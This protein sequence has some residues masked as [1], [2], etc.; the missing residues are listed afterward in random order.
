M[1]YIDIQPFLVKLQI[2]GT[3]DLKMIDTEYNPAKISAWKKSGRIR[4][5]IRGF[6]L[7]G[8]TEVNLALLCKMSNKIYAPSYVSLESAFSYYGLIPEQSFRITAVSMDKTIG[9][10]TD[11]ANFSYRKMKSSLFW[12]YRTVTVNQTKFQMAEIE[13]AIVDYLYLN[14][15]IRSA[16]DFEWLRLNREVFL[17]KANGEKL[18]KYAEMTGKGTVI[19]AAKQILD[20]IKNDRPELY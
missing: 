15:R 12:W 9:F 5:I 14:T 8:Q 2:F 16:A 20:H 17:E 3:S 1:K 7:Y 18:S 6:Y 10:D 13:K 4:Q 11:F 19:Q